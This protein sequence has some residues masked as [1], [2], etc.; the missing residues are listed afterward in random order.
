MNTT[1]RYTLDKRERLHLKHRFEALVAGRKSFISYPLRVIYRFSGR[2]EGEAPARIAISVSKKRFKRAVDRNRVKRL[3]REAY[4]LNK[5][6]LHDLIPPG[7]AVDLL[8]VYLEES[9][10]DHLKIT[11]AIQ[12]VI[13]KIRG[14]LENHGVDT[15]PAG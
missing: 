6:A 10:V 5:H 9:I 8:L 15:P 1:R 7:Q 13:K 3:T 12:G 4:R 2:N 14:I 11:K